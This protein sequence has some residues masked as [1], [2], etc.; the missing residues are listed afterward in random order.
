MS[1]ATNSALFSLLG[2]TYGGNGTTTFNLPDLR[3]RQA[4]G[5]GNGG[6]LTPRAQGEA[7][8]SETVTI[9]ANQMPIHNHTIAAST[10]ASTN[11]PGGAVYAAA[12][13]PLYADPL[14]VNK[15][16][17]ATGAMSAG[18]IASRGGS[19]AHENRQPGLTMH[20]CIAIA[21]IYPSRN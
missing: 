12:T 6:G 15:K 14:A 13:D 1:I 17:A 9:T 16:A 10:T 4:I 7:G 5:F 21:G 19:Q 2:T 11:S 3:G 18:A 20:V 8:G